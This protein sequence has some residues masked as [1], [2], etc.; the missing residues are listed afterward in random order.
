LIVN[1]EPLYERF[2][3]AGPDGSTAEIAFLKS[4]FLAMGDR[5]E[6][7]FFRAAGG[8]ADAGPREIVVGIS[9]D[10]LRRFEQVRPRRLSRE[11]KIDVAGRWLKRQ[12]ETG[13]ALDSAHLLIRDDELQ[14]MAAE[15]G[16]P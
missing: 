15:L 6:L 2:T 11:E 13:A 7:F 16:L 4:G 9:G 5:P 8:R 14:R 10:A 12:W 1:Y 3:A